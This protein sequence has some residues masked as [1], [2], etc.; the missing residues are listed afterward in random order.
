MQGRRK[1]LQDLFVDLKIAREERDA[2]PLVVDREDRILWVVGHAVAEDFQVTEPLQGVL[3]LE[4]K[5]VRR[6]RLNSTLK[7][8]LF[9]MVLV[10]VGS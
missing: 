7:S 4:S 10:V 5:A 3:L 2:V 6:P 9:W 8:L 1:K